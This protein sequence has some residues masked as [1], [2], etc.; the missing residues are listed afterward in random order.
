M[1]EKARILFVDDEKRVLNAMRGLFRRE[2][3]LFLTSEGAE[4]IRIASENAIDVIVADQRMPGMTGIEVLEQIK[5]RSP[6][7]VRI[8]L[9]GYADSGAVEGS[10]NLGEVFRFLSKPCPPNVLRETLSLAISAA[11]TRPVMTAAPREAVATPQPRPQPDV[12]AAGSPQPATRSAAAPTATAPVVEPE[13]AAT[14]TLGDDEQTQPNLP[15]LD[16]SQIAASPD[17]SAGHWQSVTNVVMSEDTV[18]EDHGHPGLPSSTLGLEDITVVVFTVDSEF[19]ADVIRAVSTDR[20]MTLA[21]TLVKV[22]QFIE[23]ES[24]GVLVTDFTT[25]KTMLQKIISALKKHMPELVTIVVSDGRDTT[26]MIN[27]IN[28]GQ[29]FRYVLKP[30]EPADLRRQINAAIVRHLYLLN[31]PESAKRHEVEL[32]PDSGETTN[33]VN[34]FVSRIRLGRASGDDSSGSPH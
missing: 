19:A 27:L 18:E 3:E 14:S 29:V 20:K 13:T 25:D 5:K 31:N 12:V 24:A 2:Y 23:Q 17:R 15:I 10:I 9:T 7:T 6:R 11:R 16:G 22:A 8:L 30:V 4:A 33:T 21:T 34:E 32:A 28:Y 1:R 26:D